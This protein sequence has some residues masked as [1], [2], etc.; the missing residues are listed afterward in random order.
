MAIER[1][2]NGIRQIQYLDKKCFYGLTYLKKLKLDHVEI[3]RIYPNAFFGLINLHDLSINFSNIGWLSMDA[4]EGLENLKTLSI[5]PGFL[6]FNV[7]YFKSLESLSISVGN[8]FMT[9]MFLKTIKTLK[10][11]K[12]YGWGITDNYYLKNVLVFAEN[13]ERL[14]IIGIHDTFYRFNYA[15]FFAKIKNLRELTISSNLIVD[16]KSIYSFKNLKKLIIE[17]DISLIF[18]NVYMFSNLR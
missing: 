12:L 10:E 15:D 7:N 3:D 17:N 9:E 18:K 13:I 4:F 11:I 16:E 14:G 8:Y 5:F 6:T 2:V 1:Q